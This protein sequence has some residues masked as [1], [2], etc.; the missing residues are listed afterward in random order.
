MEPAEP[1]A[2]VPAR[3][4]AGRRSPVGAS[5]GGGTASSSSDGAGSAGPLPGAEEAAAAA[6]ALQAARSTA[7]A[8]VERAFFDALAEGLRRGNS[9]ALASLLL[10]SRDQLAALLPQHP[11]PGG[12]S[13]GGGG[14]GEA[15]QLLAELREKLDAVRVCSGGT[16]CLPLPPHA[17]A[18]RAPTH[19]PSSTHPTHSNPLQPHPQGYVAQRLQAWD[20]PFAAQC[21]GLLVHVISRLQVSCLPAVSP[22]GRPGG[23]AR[24]LQ[25]SPGWQAGLAGPCCLG[26]EHRLSACSP[27]WPPLPLQAPARRE[28]TQAA[29][30]TV[31]AQFAAAVAAEAEPRPAAAPAASAAVAEPQ[32]APGHGRVH[33]R[34]SCSASSEAVAVQL[35]PAG[36]AAAGPTVDAGPQ[37]RL[38]L[39]PSPGGDEVAAVLA[40]AEAASSPSEEPTASGGGGGSAIPEAS[41]Q[42]AVA[43]AQFMHH[44]LNELKAD[45]AAA[46]LAM[47]KGALRC[48]R[49]A[50]DVCAALA[51]GWGRCSLWLPAACLIPPPPIPAEAILGD[52]SAIEYERQR[53]QRALQP[54]AG[55]GAAPAP[56]DAFPLTR[57]WL[58]EVLQQVRLRPAPSGG[59]RVA[60]PQPAACTVWLERCRSSLTGVLL[61]ARPCSARRRRPHRACRVRPSPK[62]QWRAGCCCCCSAPPRS[63]PPTAQARRWGQHTVG[64]GAQQQRRFGCRVPCR[65]EAASIARTTH[66][67][68]IA[69]PPCVATPGIRLRCLQRRCCLTWKGWWCCRTSCSAWPWLPPRCSSCS[70]CA[71]RSR[72]QPALRAWRMRQCTCAPRSAS[73]QSCTRAGRL[74]CPAALRSLRPNPTSPHPTPPQAQILVGQRALPPAGSPRHAAL[75]ERLVR[76]MGVLLAGASNLDALCLELHSQVNAELAAAAGSAG[77]SAGGGA[78]AGGTAGSAAPPAPPE[79]VELSVVRRMAERH[80]RTSDDVYRRVQVKRAE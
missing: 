34:L 43:A 17:G 26:P 69:D 45:V 5:A 70:R 55:S 18:P 22:D 24:C 74:S 57:A 60:R 19:A 68:R 80:F 64:C 38:Q 50:H 28:A 59:V 10:D 11:P 71:D 51:G 77:A 63:A 52:G 13:A 23:A 4:A 75:C 47:L 40:P 44:Q 33:L 1:A 20:V 27:A 3:L 21:F 48:A 66:H 32:A 49:P 31:A 2:A 39:V 56:A 8:T 73:Q 79:L 53:Y 58:G 76:R 42:A 62:P 6:E 29:F 65:P 46:R 7:V 78:G 30:A 61:L 35:A 37:W 14:G 15:H 36:A 9:A 72:A 54:P 25:A 12:S 67:R 16:R 41:V